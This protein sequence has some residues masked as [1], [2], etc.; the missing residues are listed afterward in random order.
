MRIIE[1][2][3]NITK[4]K[5]LKIPIPA[6]IKPGYHKIVVVIDEILSEN[7]TKKNLRLPVDSV[8]EW[9]ESLSLSR[10]DFYNEMGK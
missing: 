8:G 4:K 6:D 10:N 5:E 9:P 1:F 2:K 3:S 7:K